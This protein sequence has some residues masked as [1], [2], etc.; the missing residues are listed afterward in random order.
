[1]RNEFVIPEAVR[2]S[3][4]GE[5]SFKISAEIKPISFKTTLKKLQKSY[6]SNNRRL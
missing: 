4:N 6:Q 5:V 1:M 2:M 3:R